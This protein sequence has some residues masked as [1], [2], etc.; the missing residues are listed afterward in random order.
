MLPLYNIF[1]CLDKEFI[2]CTN[3]TNTFICIASLCTHAQ[4]PLYILYTHK[5]IVSK[6]SLNV[7]ADRCFCAIF[8]FVLLY[9]HNKTH[10]LQLIFVC[11]DNHN[12]GSA[13][14]DVF[15]FVLFWFCFVCAL[16]FFPL[17]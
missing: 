7:W 6:I 1:I 11:K 8:L 17:S 15:C 13:L 10:K 16:I 12:L 2:M 9:N 3:Y 5:P 14:A 4:A